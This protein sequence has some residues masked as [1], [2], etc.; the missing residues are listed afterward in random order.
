MATVIEDLSGGLTPEHELFFPGRPDNPDMRESTSIW[1]FDDLGRF[2]FPRLGIEAEAWS[3][4]N[5]RS[6]Q[7]NFGLA[8]GRILVD[9]GRGS[10]PSPFGPDGRPTV[11]GAGP[12]TFEM[13]EPFKRWRVRFDGTAAEG[14]T[15]EKIDGTLDMD[16]R[17]PV[18]LDVELTMATPGWV[19]DN[20]PDKVAL[21]NA[22]DR[23]DAESMG[24]GWRIEHLFRAE[25]SF[26]VG[27]DA[28]DFTATG[29]RVKRQSVR[30]L[31]GFRGHC[32][33]SALFPDGRAFGYIAY[34]PA[35]DGRTYNDGYVYQ[36]GR[37]YPARAVKLPWLR[38]FVAEGDDASLELESELGITRIAGTTLFSHFD[39]HNP[40]MAGGRFNLQQ[41]GARYSWDDQTAYGMLER[42]SVG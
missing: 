18:R 1:M 12:L 7:A 25:G 42:S 5:N 41:T 22:T 39:F 15:Q 26:T 37:I 30:P 13:I 29:L 33:Q 31:G 36:D 9:R 23:A 21:M 16:N 34:P 3:W 8:G 14:T 24:V 4:E 35:E 10:A 28:R 11:L 38:D 19:Q 6:Y 20:S 32:W 27:G 2:G 40:E 17:T